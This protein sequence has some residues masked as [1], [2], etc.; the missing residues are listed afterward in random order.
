MRLRD[1]L[2]RWSQVLEAVSIR[3]IPLDHRLSLLLLS[4]LFLTNRYLSLPANS[5]WVAFAAGDSYSYMAIAR[6]FPAVPAADGIAHAIV[7]EVSRTAR[8]RDRFDVVVIDPPD[9]LPGWGPTSKVPVWRHALAS[10]LALRGVR[11][12]RQVYTPPGDPEVLGLQ[13]NGRPWGPEDLRDWHAR[14]LL[15]LACR[16]NGRGGYDVV[17]FEG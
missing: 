7:D 9:R 16:P 8:A 17:P 3:K 14:G 4:A 5:R 10:A 15:V 12:A 13:R 11:L 2:D 1:R 6:A